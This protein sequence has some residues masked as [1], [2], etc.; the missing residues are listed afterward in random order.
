MTHMPDPQTAEPVPNAPADE[1]AARSRWVLGLILLVAAALL[2]KQMA[3]AR[4][5]T[6]DATGYYLP[7]A[8]AFAAFARIATADAT[9]YYLPLARAFAAG[10]GDEAQNIIIPPLYPM[11][12]GFCSPA[13]AWADD[14]CEQ[15]GRAVSAIA[16]LALVVL[17]YALGAELGSRRVGLVAAALTATNRAVIR[18]GVAVGPDMFYAALLAGLALLVLKYRARARPALA[19]AIGAAAALAALVRSEGLLL[20]G[21]AGVA[22]ALAPM[23]GARRRWGRRMLGVALMLAA[24]AVVWLPRLDYMKRKTGWA[25]LDIRLV[26]TLDRGRF[27]QDPHVWLMPRQ[28]YTGTAHA[29]KPAKPPGARVGE[30]VESL[31]DVIGYASWPL[32]VFWLVAGRRHLA[33]RP[34][35]VV[36]AAMLVMELGVLA[37][38]VLGKR[39]VTIVT[40]PAQVWAALGAVALGEC[41]RRRAA[42][43]QAA[44]AVSRRLLAGLGVLLVVSAGVSLFSTNHGSRHTERRDLGRLARERLG[45][46]RIILAQGPQL[47]YYADARF[48]IATDSRHGGEMDAV[49]LGALCRTHDADLIELGTKS[50]SSRWLLEQITSA[51]LPAG[52]LVAER[53]GGEYT[54]YLIDARKLFGPY[55]PTTKP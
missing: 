18:I 25:V 22:I 20:V 10:D 4:I 29:L 42:G 14:P 50:P 11:V 26:N 16:A 19:G 32:I 9:G 13:F 2:G 54:T 27:E 3:F 51:R 12:V 15:A 23:A 43:A 8:R 46:G 37:T 6:A 52:A 45:R 48:I 40:G 17:V 41:L 44:A 5:A 1:S 39:Y 49:A 30:A 35:R 36:L 34:G 7:L 28:V 24:A 53:S 33:K 55:S 38:V 47:P 31:A 21:F